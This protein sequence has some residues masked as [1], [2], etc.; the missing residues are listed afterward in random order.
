MCIFQVV[1]LENG[2]PATGHAVFC[3]DTQYHAIEQSG[4]IVG[5]GEDGAQHLTSHIGRR[6]LVTAVLID[7]LVQQLPHGDGVKFIISGLDD[8]QPL[9]MGLCIAEK[10]PKAV[11]QEKAHRETGC[12]G[13]ESQNIEFH[14]GVHSFLGQ[15]RSISAA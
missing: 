9:L 1:C 13:G 4:R 3:P 15:F 10:G 11:A 12:I 7:G 5:I 2:G 8:L 14:I 6:G